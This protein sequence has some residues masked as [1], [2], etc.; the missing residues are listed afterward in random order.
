[1]KTAHR[2]MLPIY[3]H[4]KDF[5]IFFFHSAKGTS[6]GNLIQ[7]I[8]KLHMIKMAKNVTI[9]LNLSSPNN[10][11]LN[12]VHMLK[13]YFL[14]ERIEIFLHWMFF[15]KKCHFSQILGQIT[16]SSTYLLIEFIKTT[17]PKIC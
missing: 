5:T 12:L 11:I 9:G 8:T 10:G 17:F 1:M 4:V 6:F 15:F 3:N 7:I 2:L 13:S 16:E 14:K